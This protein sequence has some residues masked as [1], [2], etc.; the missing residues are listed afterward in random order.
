MMLACS[1]ADALTFLLVLATQDR[2]VLLARRHAAIL[3]ARKPL[4]N[5]LTDRRVWECHSAREKRREDAMA[6]PAAAVATP[7]DVGLKYTSL[8]WLGLNGGVDLTYKIADKTAEVYLC[9]GAED[10]RVLIT[11]TTPAGRRDDVLDAIDE[12]GKWGENIKTWMVAEKSGAVV[13][14][15]P[16]VNHLAHV[17]P[18]YGELTI[19]DIANDGMTY[20]GNGI[21]RWLSPRINE[22]YYFIYGSKLENSNPMRGFDCTTFPMALFGMQRLPQPGYGKQLCDALGATT[23]GLEQI[24]RADLEQKFKDD[25][26]PIGIY[27]LFSEGHVLLYNSDINTLYEF[28]YGG[29]KQTPAAE[30]PMKATHN[31]WWMRKLTETYRSCFQSSSGAGRSEGCTF[32]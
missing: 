5:R 16:V 23:C 15:S 31:L 28:T 14:R 27:V 7:A 6:S 13:A 18:F 11:G 2:I 32:R 26:I 22:R 8:N 29:F 21:G 20:A 30:R 19:S 24:K 3:V 1:R 9:V 10:N 25:S 4:R 12:F 17:K